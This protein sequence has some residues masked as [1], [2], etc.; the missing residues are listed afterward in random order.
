M[1]PTCLLVCALGRKVVGYD[2]SHSKNLEKVKSVALEHTDIDPE[3]MVL[4]HSDGCGATGV[5]RSGRISGT[6]LRLTLHICR[7]RYTD[8]DRCLGNIKDQDLFLERME[9][10]LVN[11][12]R[13][14]KPSNWEKKIFHPIVKTGS[15]SSWKVGSS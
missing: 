4:H 6:L 10:C 5:R 8:D 12:K 13:L 1:A 7:E 14:I 3:D 11:P 2:P 9:L 15:L